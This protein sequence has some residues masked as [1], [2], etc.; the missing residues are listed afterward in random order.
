MLQLMLVDVQQ[1]TLSGTIT[2]W[3]EEDR[4]GYTWNDL[5][6]EDQV[7]SNLTCPLECLVECHVDGVP[8]CHQPEDNRSNPESFWIYLGLR[9]IA[10][11]FLSSSFSMLV[12]MHLF[13]LV[14]NN[15]Q[16]EA[17]FIYILFQN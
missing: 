3:R 15:W 12:C 7:F 17:H 9:L 4:C 5:Q 11:V 1:M 6:H 14:A 2:S 13:C 10:N 16:N 8:P